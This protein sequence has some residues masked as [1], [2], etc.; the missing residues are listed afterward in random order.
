MI[1]IQID[2]H[3]FY[4]LL[5][6]T[7]KYLFDDRSYGRETFDEVKVKGILKKWMRFTVK[8]WNYRRIGR[9]GYHILGERIRTPMNMIQMWGHHFKRWDH[10]I[11]AVDRGSGLVNMTLMWGLHFKRWDHVIIGSVHVSTHL[12]K[13]KLRKPHPADLFSA[14]FVTMSGK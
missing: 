1:M 3:E 14:F 11:L 6:Y 4:S 2:H 12:G 7:S 13:Y 8:H 5:L 10:V 9:S